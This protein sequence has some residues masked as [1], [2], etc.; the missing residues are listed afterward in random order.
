MENV[1]MCAR[2]LSVLDCLLMGSSRSWELVGQAL[3]LAA[4]AGRPPARVGLRLGENAYPKTLCTFPSSIEAI[5]QGCFEQGP[6]RNSRGQFLKLDGFKP[7]S[8]S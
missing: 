2:E 6:K 5:A 7:S 8:F 3:L 4:M 1:E